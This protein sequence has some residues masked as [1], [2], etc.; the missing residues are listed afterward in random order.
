MNQTAIHHVVFL[1][2]AESVGNAENR[3]QGHADFPLTERGLAQARALA[4]RWRAERVTFDRAIASPLRRARQ[5]A[6]IVCA[7]LGLPLTFDPG[8]MEIN[9]GRMAGLT[10]EEEERLFPRP[11]FVTPYTHYGETGES[12]WELYLRAG[13]NIQRLVDSPPGRILVVAHGGILNMAMYAMLNIPLQANSSGPRFLFRNLAF[14]TLEYHAERHNWYL[15]GFDGGAP[16]EEA[17]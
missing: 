15:L 12:R 6:E 16:D 9:N 1:R 8:W 14:A 11:A 3:F 13:A 7:A 5:T 2:H 10:A 4:E 17:E